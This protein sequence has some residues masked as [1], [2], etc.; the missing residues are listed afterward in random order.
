MS[1]F[2]IVL[3][4]LW[5]IICAL[6]IRAL[7]ELGLGASAVFLDDFRQP[8]RAMINSD[9]SIH[10]LMVALWIL[11]RE[12]SP[13]VGVLCALGEFIVGM[14]FTLMYLLVVTFR[15]KGDMRRVLLG[16]HFAA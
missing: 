15:E 4:V 16:R 14:P 10:L 12:R 11:Y 9:F 2:R 1:S 7:V 13:T 6:V 3:L 8:W 5:I